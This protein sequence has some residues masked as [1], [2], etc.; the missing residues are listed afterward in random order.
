[1]TAKLLVLFTAPPL[2]WLLHFPLPAFFGTVATIW[3]SDEALNAALAPP[4]ATFFTPERC[5]PKIVTFAPAWAL[6]GLKY[7]ITGV[8]RVAFGSVTTVKP[9]VNLPSGDAIEIVLPPGEAIL[10]SK[11]SVPSGTTTVNCVPVLLIA[12]AELGTTIGIA[13]T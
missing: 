3:L 7:V 1:M 4:S 8:P 10:P 2:H 13:P 6:S 5:V 12:T 11:T 9:V